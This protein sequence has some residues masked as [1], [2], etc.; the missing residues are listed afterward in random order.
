MTD[1]HNPHVA[2]YAGDSIVDTSALD[3]LALAGTRFDTAYCQSPLCSPSRLSLLT[4]KWVPNC[5]A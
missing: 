4:G 2:G 5:S 3:G 1:Q